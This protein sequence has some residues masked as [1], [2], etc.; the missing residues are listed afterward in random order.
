MKLLVPG[1]AGFIASHL[2]DPGI[3][4]GHKVV[5][6]DA[7]SRGSMTIVNSR[8]RLHQGKEFLIPKFQL[9]RKFLSSNKGLP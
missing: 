8:A 9:L 2:A 3:A 6:S 5:V 4:A 7:L 1:E